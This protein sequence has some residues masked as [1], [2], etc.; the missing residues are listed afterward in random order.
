MWRKRLERLMI[1]FGAL[2]FSTQKFLPKWVYLS[3]YG[4]GALCF[5][6]W[7]CVPLFFPPAK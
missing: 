3:L 5:V 2:G 4:C 7:L 6:G 1:M